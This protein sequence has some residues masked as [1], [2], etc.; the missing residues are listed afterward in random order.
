MLHKYSI[1]KIYLEYC[2]NTQPLDNAQTP[3]LESHS[4]ILARI[5]HKYFKEECC[6]STQSQSSIPNIL[7]ILNPGHFTNV[8]NPYVAQT[9]YPDIAQI[10][11]S[12]HCTN[13]YPKSNA[14]QTSNL[15]IAKISIFGC[16]TNIQNWMLCKHPTWILQKHPSLSIIQ[17]FEIRCYINIEPRYCT[18]T[19]LQTLHNIQTWMLH[20]YPF[21]IL[22]KY[23]LSAII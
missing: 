22:Y 9:L 5:H 17:M 6:R 19:Y 2:T 11:T 13:K 10:S 21:W 15:D 1:T 23:P 14:T 16:C 8:Q 12:R 4:G 20:R 7:Q 18:N 3:K